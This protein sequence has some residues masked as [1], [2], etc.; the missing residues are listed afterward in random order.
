MEND[1]VRPGT[2][3][4]DRVVRERGLR[5]ARGAAPCK[6]RPAGSE[7][8]FRE[9]GVLTMCE[10]E[11]EARGVNRKYNISHSA[12]GDHSPGRCGQRCWAYARAPLSAAS[13]ARSPAIHLTCLDLTSYSSPHANCLF[14]PRLKRVSRPHTRPHTYALE[15]PLQ[16]TAALTSLLYTSHTQP[17]RDMR[18]I[19]GQLSL[20]HTHT[21]RH[22]NTSYHC[23]SIFFYKIPIRRIRETT[24]ACVMRKLAPRTSTITWT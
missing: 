20:S 19:D 12:S 4:Y 21:E 8:E 17:T 3:G 13:E 22:V 6:P 23:I 9:A 15:T 5:E 11:T 2:T 24:H 1:G 10:T 14:S 16:L 7:G 18:Y